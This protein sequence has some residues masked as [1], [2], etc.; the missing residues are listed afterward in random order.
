LVGH[1][2]LKLA[3]KLTTARVQ[4]GHALAEP[5]RDVAAVLAL[6]GRRRQL[7]YLDRDD[8]RLVRRALT[9]GVAVE[10]HGHRSVEVVGECVDDLPR[11]AL[12]RSR[13]GQVLDIARRPQPAAPLGRLAGGAALKVDLRPDQVAPGC[14]ERER[15]DSSLGRVPGRRARV[16]ARVPVARP[17]RTGS[18][19]ASGRAAVALVA[20]RPLG[21]CRA[22]GQLVR[23]EVDLPERAV[24]DLGR[25]DRVRPDLRAPDA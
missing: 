7:P 15:C 8:P 21:A 2:T 25:V 12:H 10:V 9:A 22:G 23:A 13:Y 17:D 3:A 14:R 4:P 6:A 11:Q 19:L 5:V 20:L 24:L 1:Q 16:V 18:A